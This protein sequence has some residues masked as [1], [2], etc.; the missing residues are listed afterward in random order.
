MEKGNDLHT[1]LHMLLTYRDAIRMEDLADALYRLKSSL[2][3]VLEEAERL[4]E[5]YDCRLR[6]RLNYGL[7]LEGHEEDIR[8]LFYRFVDTL[9]MQGYQHNDLDVRLPDASYEK[10]KM[11]FDVQMIRMI[12][13]T[14]R[15]SEINPN[16]HYYD[17]DF[18][19]P[20][21]KCCI[22]FTRC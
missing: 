4:A 22:L 11:V 2:T 7:S 17:Y 9:P 10:M 14:A 12:I 13:P 21:L 18:G 3:T 20:I 16:T 19:V 15:S 6:K 1:V 5:N 8:S